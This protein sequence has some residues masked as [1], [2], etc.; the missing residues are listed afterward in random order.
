[1]P[2]GPVKAGEIKWFTAIVTLALRVALRV[3]PGYSLSELLVSGSNGWF[4]FYLETRDRV[5][6]GFIVFDCDDDVQG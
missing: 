4:L 5:E 3:I 6:V 1:M 2:L